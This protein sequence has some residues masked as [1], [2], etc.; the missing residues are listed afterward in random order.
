M[1][2]TKGKVC[3][4]VLLCLAVAAASAAVVCWRPSRTDSGPAGATQSVSAAHVVPNDVRLCQ[5]SDSCN[6][7]SGCDAGG[8]NCN[9]QANRPIWGVDCADGGCAELGWAACRPIDWQ[10]Y[11]QG[12][13]VGHARIPHV[14]EYRIR[15]DDIL[16]IVYRLTRDE[17]SKPYELQV[18][19]TIQVQSFTDEKLNH[20]RVVVQS[21]GTITLNL[22]GAVRA[23]RHTIPD[24][25]DAIEEK[26]KEFYKVPA[27]SVTPVLTN[28]KLQDLLNAVDARYGTGGQRIQVRVTPEGTIQLPGVGSIFSHGLTIRELDHE[29]DE[30]YRVVVEG[31]E[32]TVILT[33]RAPRYAY[34]LGEVAQPGRITLDSPTTVMMAIA[35][36]QGWNDMDAN[37]RQ[38]VVFRRGD[39]WRLMATMLD[40]QGPLYG[41]RPCPADE[42]WLND[43]DIVVV[44]KTPIR[45]ANEFIEQV[46][47]RGIYGVVPQVATG[48]GF[49]FSTTTS[50]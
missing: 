32:A 26:Y 24:L 30:R 44:P 4:R 39:D 14:P 3:F 48:I 16:E 28:T 25:R 38:V 31:V 18:G 49:D 23:T 43:S 41:R 36:A 6:A 50:L 20:P 11:A 29:V 19:D 27:I 15:V 13:Y 42:I 21:D 45:I 46:F 12:E 7:G 37:L 8:G 1:N 35:Q 17:T 9:A 40:I 33:Q 2:T 10:A 47:T 34:V 5:Y 22:L